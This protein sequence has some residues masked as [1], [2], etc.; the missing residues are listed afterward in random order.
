MMGRFIEVVMTVTVP[1]PGRPH[2]H[3]PPQAGAGVPHHRQ[4]QGREKELVLA[5]IEV[6][7]SDTNA[8]LRE[9]LRRLAA[10]GAST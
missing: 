4:L 2:P 8:L 1:H 10:R 6:W 7:S 3:R 9:K 5:I